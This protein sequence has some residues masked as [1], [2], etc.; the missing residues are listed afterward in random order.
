MRYFKG[1]IKNSTGAGRGIRTLDCRKFTPS[2]IDTKYPLWYYT[3]S[4]EFLC[5]FCDNPTYYRKIIT[6]FSTIKEESH[7]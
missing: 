4:F 7:L 2:A 6:S 1:K 5:L 3:F